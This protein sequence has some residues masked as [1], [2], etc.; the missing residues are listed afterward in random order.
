MKK[1]YKWYL[2]HEKICGECGYISEYSKKLI[3]DKPKP[4]DYYD[5]HIT[6]IYWCWTCSQ[7]TR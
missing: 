7:Q 5:R 3:T 2:Y 6:T 4:K 1:K